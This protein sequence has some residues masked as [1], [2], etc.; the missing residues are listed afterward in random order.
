MEGLLQGASMGARLLHSTFLLCVCSIVHLFFCTA[1]W[2]FYGVF[3]A[4]AVECNKNT[5][6]FSYSCTKIHKAYWLG[7]MLN[8]FRSSILFKSP[9]Q[10]AGSC[11]CFL[12]INLLTFIFD[13][14]FSF[15]DTVSTHS[16]S[17]DS[18]WQLV[19]VC[20]QF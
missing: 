20:W 3:V 19:D 14:S 7:L 8:Q 15:V 18:Y 2:K 4:H 13:D 1:V 17:L 12:S 5:M 16:L 6:T 11:A 10:S 9:R